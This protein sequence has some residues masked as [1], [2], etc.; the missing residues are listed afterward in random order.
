MNQ[1]FKRLRITPQLLT[2]GYKIDH[3]RQYVKETVG[4]YSNMTPRKSRIPG[5]NDV[6]VFGIQYYLI[7]TLITIWNEDFFNV[8]WEV[9]EKEF[10]QEMEEY[11]LSKEAAEAI[12][13]THWKE[14]HDLGYL[15]L[16]IKALPEGTK[17]PIRVP[18]YT[19]KNTDNRF[20]WLTNFIET[21]MSAE[22]WGAATS[23]TLADVYY[24]IFD[25]W[26]EISG[27][28]R[29]FVKFQGH[30]FSYR[31]ML[32]REAA[33]IVD[34]GHLTRFYGSDTIPGRKYMK[35]YYGADQSKEIISCSV[36]ATEHAVMCS[37]TGFYILK[38][39]LTW[40]RYGDAEFSV[41]KRLL[42][43]VYPTGIVSIVSDTWDLWQVLLD[44]MVRMKDII[45]ARDGK[46]VIRPD[47]G[48]P[49]KIMTGYLS[50]EYDYDHTTGKY[51][52][53]IPSEVRPGV[54]NRGKELKGVEVDGVI[55]TLFN[56]FGGELNKKGFISLNPKVGAIYGD[57][58]TPQR[59]EAI[60]QRL[61]EGRNFESTVWVAGI[62]SY[63]YQYVT[64]DTFGFAQKATNTT[65]EL[66]G[67]V[68]EIPIFK[69]PVTDDGTKKSARGLLQVYED[70]AHKFYLRDQVSWIEEEDS[71]LQTVFLNGQLTKEFTLHE[72]RHT[73]DIAA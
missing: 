73:L 43:E 38:D 13:T 12:G 47:S 19:V 36:F 26:A 28:D 52:T 7:S 2:D 49:V 46:I 27:A 4:V 42:T 44:Y 15:P 17:C 21:D 31:G 8:P 66:N 40:E 30:N 48:D 72:I 23:A 6:V 29:S 61:V 1:R 50:G 45:L 71:F 63:T 35:H 18:M 55:Q 22:V 60:C 68:Y 3:R 39:G 24:K 59:A 10:I 64:R 5:V 14:L 32:G 20:Y 11:T 65:I 33:C 56:I 54:M 51:Y 67:V 70:E 53:L 37:V 58:I 9:L 16:C 34:M 57:S 62:G 25:K 41:F 69:D